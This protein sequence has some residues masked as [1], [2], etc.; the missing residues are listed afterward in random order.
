MGTWTAV[1][2][3]SFGVS[4]AATGCVGHK[5]GDGSTA[6][7][8]KAEVVQIAEATAKSGGYDVSKY[9]MTGCHYEFTRKDRSWTVFYALKP[10]T[11][12]GAHFLVWVDDQTKKAT[13]APGE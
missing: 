13:L 1:L 3:M 12:V 2:T 5:R 10:P 11:P 4:L 9:N 6:N 8:T 7:L